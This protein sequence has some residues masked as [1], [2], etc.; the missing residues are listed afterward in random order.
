MANITLRVGDRV[1][2]QSGGRLT[3]GRV[4]KI[5]FESGRIGDFVYD[6]SRDFPRYIVETDEGHRAAHR[7]EALS[8]P[9]AERAHTTWIHGGGTT[10][11]R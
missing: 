7:P 9:Q 8:R 10:D 5:A 1:R 11:P 2:W 4:I 3:E 6:A